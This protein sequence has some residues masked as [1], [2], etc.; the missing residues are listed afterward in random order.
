ME[1]HISI[2][3]D[4]TMNHHHDSWSPWI[5]SFHI[6]C[7]FKH[8]TNVGLYCVHKGPYTLIMKTLE[9]ILEEKAMVIYCYFLKYLPQTANTYPCVVSYFDRLYNKTATKDTSKETLFKKSSQ[10]WRKCIYN[11]FVLFCLNTQVLSHIPVP[12]LESAPGM[13][14][15]NKNTNKVMGV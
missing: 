11:S 5:L 13:S 4:E 2:H 14:F 1:C 8:K 6:K 7:L 3:G 10:R 12:S 9:N 15:L